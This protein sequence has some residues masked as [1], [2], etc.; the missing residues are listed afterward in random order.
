MFNQIQKERVVVPISEYWERD[1]VF[2]RSDFSMQ[3]MTDTGNLV[4]HEGCVNAINFNSTGS[5]LVTGS[6]DQAVKIWD[7]STRKCLA[8]LQGHSSNVFAT[9][10]LPEKGDREVISGG[11]D[12]DIRYYNLNS[13]ENLV[14]QHH[15]RKVLS[16]CVNPMNP[17]CFISCSADGTI[18]LFDIRNQYKRTKLEKTQQSTSS[19]D[20]DNHPSVIPQALG[21][22]RRGAGT[23]LSDPLTMDSLLINYN[24]L[25]RD[26]STVYS[27]DISPNGN[28]FIA[29]SGDGNVRM[30]DFRYIKPTHNPT[31]CFV[32]I[33]RN[34]KIKPDSNAEATGCQFSKDGTEVVSTL[35][36]DKIYVF[37]VNRNYCKEFGLDYMENDMKKITKILREGAKRSGGSSSNSETSSSTKLT[38]SYPSNP[39]VH[40]ADFVGGTSSNLSNLAEGKSAEGSKIIKTTPVLQEGHASNDNN[41]TSQKASSGDNLRLPTS[42][43]N[44]SINSEEGRDDEGKEAD[45]DNVYM[46]DQDLRRENV[47]FGE[48]DDE[49]EEHSRSSFED[50]ALIDTM[51][52]VYKG[53]CSQQTIKGVY[54]YGPNSEYVMSGSDDAKI[55]IW[56]KKTGKLVRI[57]EG[58]DSTV[59]T[60]A[61]HPTLP[62]LASSGIDSYIKIWQP[63]GDYPDKET[64]EKRLARMKAIVE[65]NESGELPGRS[66]TRLA[67][68]NIL[69]LLN[70]FRFFQ[71]QH[72]QLDDEDDSAA[73]NE[74]NNSN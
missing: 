51:K 10:F 9:L 64:M 25:S 48:K 57:L 1:S 19:D 31:D 5:L 30:F 38:S 63:N 65:E 6:D 70:L 62:V 17:N 47:E 71:Q 21:G 24:S 32:N 72:Q 15:K 3:T 49:D 26:M 52:R 39:D 46:D 4:G 27:V 37:D 45:A 66:E 54:F 53:H 22:G 12:S 41:N 11:N 60:I 56:D 35:L 14:Y 40:P 73:N 61:A 33:F 69:Y 16:L 42:T 36:S 13:Q 28:N 20:S 8:S 34:I 67:S 74:G 7:F 44:V 59:N 2:Y 23:T 18:R 58:H 43:L 29:G 55:F 50:M 68:N